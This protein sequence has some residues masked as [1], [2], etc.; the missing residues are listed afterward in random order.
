MSVTKSLVQ[1]C[2]VLSRLCRTA[3]SDVSGLNTAPQAPLRHQ[4]LLLKLQLLAQITAL[5]PCAACPL[6]QGRAKQP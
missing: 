3:L 1:S 2:V 5:L 6:R 4:G